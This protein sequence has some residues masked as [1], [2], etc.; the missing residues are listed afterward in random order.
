MQKFFI[1]FSVMLL[2]S[3]PARA[4]SITL[5]PTATVSGFQGIEKKSVP[6]N[7]I[8]DIHGAIDNNILE[9]S[10]AQGSL[11]KLDGL[12]Y[13]CAANAPL[14][15]QKNIHIA[16]FGYYDIKDVN[17]VSGQIYTGQTEK[18]LLRSS[19]YERINTP[20]KIN[21][22]LSPQ[23][24]SECDSQKFYPGKWLSFT[25]GYDNDSTHVY[26][27]LYPVHWKPDTREIA[28]LKE[29]TISISG[30]KREF[31]S[32][33]KVTAL[34]NAQHLILTPPEWISLAD[35]IALMH[36]DLGMKSHVVNVEEIYDT[37]D[38]AEDPS[39]PGYAFTQNPDIHNY[40]FN[41]AKKII[42]YLRDRDAHPRI[43]FVTIL[44]SGKI[45][46]PSY[47]FYF[48]VQILPQYDA[49]LS[50][51]PSDQYYSSPDYDWVDNVTVNRISVH[52]KEQLATYY[53]KM[54]E[55]NKHLDE[56]W[57]ENVSVSGGIP[58][59][60]NFFLGELC[61]NHII[62]SDIF[63]GCDIQKFQHHLGNYDATSLSNHLQSDNILWHYNDSHGS[64]R[65]IYFDDNSHIDADEV[66]IFPSKNMLPVFLSLACMNGNFDTDMVDNPYGT[67]LSFG[68][69]MI[70]SKGGSIAYLGGSRYTTGDV[71]TALENGNIQFL[72]QNQLYALLYYYMQ[73]YREVEKPYLGSMFK[74]AKEKFLLEQNMGEQSNRIAYVQFVGMCDA[75]LLLPE[76][77]AM[78]PQT[79]VPTI[80][81]QGSL[82]NPDDDFQIV[83][84]A[85]NEDPIYAISDSEA[86]EL[87][88]INVSSGTSQNGIP[89]TDQFTLANLEG[90]QLILNKLVNQ[91]GK[92]AWHYSI[93][94]KGLKKMDGD[95]SDWF[96]GEMIASDES[97]EI[98]PDEFDLT[99]LYSVF[100][101]KNN[102]LHFALPVQP[103]PEN[104]NI[105]YILAFD[106]EDSFGF[107]NNILAEDPFPFPIYLG[108][109]NATMNKLIVLQT[110]PGD[111]FESPYE[112]SKYSFFEYVY[113]NNLPQYP[114]W[115]ERP[116]N[117][118]ELGGIAY[119]N[120]SVIEL[121]IPADLFNLAALSS[122]CI[123]ICGSGH[124]GRCDTFLSEQSDKSIVWS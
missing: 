9:V 60:T 5:N 116:I 109:D 51:I 11:L 95:L 29:Y 71:F 24:Q 88:T 86:Y 82:E 117:E 52:S 79:T 42:A 20:L 70:S 45:I 104:K 17:L 100:D 59:G 12:S 66:M 25:A 106:D 111:Y 118:K 35:S 4:K 120:D 46:P 27:H 115:K 69:A 65:G 121:S 93:V 32:P 107:R 74:A 73:A 6:Q 14:L 62:C 80:S 33:R 18:D 102:V 122:G 55:W 10:T 34:M 92:E 105:Y 90:N 112:V 39:H 8:H 61:N 124:Y 30:Q 96:P 113:W 98:Q 2:L 54:Q 21:S 81:A 26:I 1:V 19:T 97:G 76:P 94:N 101:D 49:Y 77:P 15:P 43:Q 57:V 47:Y 58:C 123:F 50:W 64:G 75:A 108:F 38:P 48:P 110:E 91:E 87:R 36:N 67:G 37:Y 63:Y 7:A 56:S 78:N 44:G 13:I 31:T 84:L 40:N 99:A 23:Q 114:Y 22:D 41:D 68:E 53:T 85:Q 72:G 83:N 89:V 16:L 103:A 28:F 3:L 119:G